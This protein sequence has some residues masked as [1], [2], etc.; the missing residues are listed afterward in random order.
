MLARVNDTLCPDI[1][2]NMFVTCF[3]GVLDPAS[4]HLRYANAGHNLPLVHAAGDASELRATGMPLGLMP[5]M[6]YEERETTLGDRRL[7]AALQRRAGRGPR[8]RARDVRDRA[9]RSSCSR[10]EPDARRR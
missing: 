2:E 6:S 3:Y 10:R 5:G 4:G 8:R 1:P 9:R 7:R